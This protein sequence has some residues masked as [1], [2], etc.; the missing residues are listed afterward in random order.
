MAA[1]LPT[2]VALATPPGPGAIGIVRLT[3]PASRAVIRTLIPSLP[4]DLPE[5]RVYTGWA[6]DPVTGER[7]DQVIAFAFDP[8][9][10][11][12]GQEAAEIHGH[13]GP[14]VLDRLLSAALLAGA[15]PAP[16]GEFTRRAFLTGRIDLLQAEAVAL[17]VAAAGERAASASAVQLAGGLSQEFAASRAPLVTALAAVEACLDFPD[18]EVPAPD[19]SRLASLLDESAAGLSRLLATWHGARRIFQGIRVV[20]AGPPNAGKS[21]LFNR[22]LGRSR[23]LVDPEPGTTRDYLEAR[24]ER[25]GIGLAL[26]DTAGMRDRPGRIEQAGMELSRE[27][28]RSA[29]VILLVV[30]GSGIT[31]GA[32][33]L[34]GEA[35]AGART[36]VAINKIDL[37]ERMDGSSLSLLDPYPRFEVSALTGEGVDALGAHLVEGEAATVDLEGPVLT[38]LR[39][40]DL[41]SRATS[42]IDRAAQAV[43]DGLPAEIVASEIRSALSR[44]DELTG[45]ETVPD[46]LDEIFSRFCIGK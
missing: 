6:H 21:S 43:R 45:R 23:A 25:G 16:P 10:S 31:A 42:D 24:V 46:V 29:D 12:T 32:L 11:H 39:H 30:D 2:I 9:S 26:V 14:H 34:L 41:V 36:V 17:I 37:D 8:A 27:A 40:R 19:P 4:P 3:G 20:L 44:I 15:E 18:D 13:G 35:S 5:R 22:L 7:I 28:V 1:D 38:C 33:A